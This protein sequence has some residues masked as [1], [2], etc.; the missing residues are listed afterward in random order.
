MCK[1]RATY[2]EMNEEA[3]EKAHRFASSIRHYD[4]WT[5]KPVDKISDLLPK[6]NGEKCEE[7]GTPLINNCLTCGAPICCPKCCEGR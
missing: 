4:R 5:G 2:E 7:C 6:E 3:I 1:R